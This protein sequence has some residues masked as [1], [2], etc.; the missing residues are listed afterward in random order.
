VAAAAALA[1]LAGGCSGDP[2]GPAAP[3]ADGPSYGAHIP[4]GTP[5]GMRAKQVMDMLNSDWPIGHGNVSTLATPEAVEETIAGMDPLW[6]DRPVTLEHVEIGA[7]SAALRVHNAYGAEHDIELSVDGDT[8][9]DEFTVTL[10]PPRIGD[11]ADIDAVLG[12]SGARYSYQVARVADGRCHRLAGANTA[13]SLPLASIFK[14]YVLLAVADAVKAGTLSWDEELVLTER[15][16][17]LGSTVMEELQPGARV[18]VRWAAQQM[19]SV[20]DN[21][22]TD[23]LIERVGREAVERALVA[24]GHHDPESMRPFPTMHELFSVGWGEP[25]LR[26]RWKNASRA[27]RARLLAEADERPL[28]PDPDRT[29][30]PGSAYGAE[31]YGSAEDIC[32]LHVALQRAAV[33]PAAPVR[34]ILS[35]VPGITLDRAVW[36]YIGAKGGNLPGDLTFSWYAEDR[37]GVPYV[38]SFQ[39]TWPQYRSRTAATWLLAIAQQAFGLIQRDQPAGR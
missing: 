31:W 27:D 37:T 10:H 3:A 21:V 6:W 26:E 1:L 34:D 17:A 19:I 36:P 13:E 12:A 9:V 5:Q 30:S 25:D 28:N 18:S 29:F 23:L 20:S 24:A 38:V 14:L 11:W 39:L 2:S 22:A 15:A 35:A 32:R 4:T 16:K 33:G 7:G 8:L